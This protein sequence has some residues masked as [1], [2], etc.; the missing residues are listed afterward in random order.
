M[1]R[2]VPLTANE[3]ALVLAYRKAD[4]RGQRS[5][6]EFAE[7]T[8]EDWPKPAVCRDKGGVSATA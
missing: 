3:E 2:P 7:S 8:A 5:V 1:N 6:F 4:H